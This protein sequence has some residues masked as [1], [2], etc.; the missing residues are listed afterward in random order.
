[1]FTHYFLLKLI[2]APLIII[3]ATMITRKWGEAIGGLIIGLPLTSAPVSIFFAIEQGRQFAAS[4][5]K[6]AMLGLIP[7]AVFCAGYSLSSRRW[8]W[9][10][11]ALTGISL[12]LVTVW[13]MASVNPNLETVALLVPCALAGALLIAG[14]QP[15]DHPKMPSPWWDL[16]L[17]VLVAAALLIGITTAADALGPIWSGLLSPFPIF[18]FVMA[19]FSQHQGGPGAAW[20]VIR[21]VLTGLFSYT[22]FFLVAA[23][24][25]NR[26]SLALVYTLAT[27]AA[28]G[29]NGA[30]LA[31]MVWKSRPA[32][33]KPAGWDLPRA[34]RR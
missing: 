6:A 8:N 10:V 19:T 30:M 3:T 23:L 16:P 24:L 27:T 28:L 20:R 5:A 31:R 32:V 33:N 18:T 11:S 4:A 22:A 14:K 17:R 29:L 26:A 34:P 15:A 21:G 12:Y 7:V 9:V 2:L 1:M 25:M 13:G